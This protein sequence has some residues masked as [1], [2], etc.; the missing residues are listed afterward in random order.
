MKAESP[1]WIVMGEPATPAEAEALDAFREVL[2]EDG[3]TTAWVNLTFIDDNGR[4]AEVDVL[5][6][7][8]AGFFVVELKG[9]HGT[10]RGTTQRW[11]HGVRNVENPWLITDRKGKRLAG[12]LKGYAPSPA[13]QKTVPFVNALVVLHGNDSTVELEDRARGG[14]V[15]LDGF[16]VNAR[17]ALPKISDFL[18]RPPANPHHAIDIIRARQVRTLCER[19][20]FRAT[21]KARMVGDFAVAETAPIAEGPDWQDVLVSLPAMPD[22]NRRLRLYDIPSQGLGERATARRTVGQA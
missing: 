3:I 19:A 11:V 2:P 7:T 12:L 14:V 13:A 5:L 9:W 15:T 22:V 21:P 18:A 1:H 6:L 16:R 10:I 4:S 20:D 8:R 17:P